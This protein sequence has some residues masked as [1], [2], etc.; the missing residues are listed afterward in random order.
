MGYYSS[1]SVDAVIAV[2]EYVEGAFAK[3][4]TYLKDRKDYFGYWIHLE[5][6]DE[7]EIAVLATGES[8]KAYDWDSELQKFC[9][10]LETMDCYLT[11]V[12]YR[13]GE[14]SDDLERFLVANNKITVAKAQLVFPD[15][16]VYRPR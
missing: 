6:N 11:G 1:I 4:D 2:D 3:L 8:G 12:F 5:E 9:D 7:T 13:D 15:G 14:E 10:F 16:E